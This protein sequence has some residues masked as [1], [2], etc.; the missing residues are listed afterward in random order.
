MTGATQASS[1]NARDMDNNM[2]TIRNRTLLT[3][4]TLV[5]MI[6]LNGCQTEEVE[7]AEAPA[8]LVATHPVKRDITITRDYVCQIHSNRHIELRTLEG[9]YLQEVAVKEGQQVARGQVMFRILPLVYQAELQRATAEAQAARLEYQNTAKL[10]ESN[11]VSATEL[12]LSKAK[13]EKAKAEVNLAQAHLNF[14]EIKAPFDGIMDRLHVR[15]GSLLEEGELLT[16]L[17]DNSLMWVYFNVPEA[18]YLDYAQHAG[19]DGEVR[20]DL[21]MANNE[22]FAHPGEMAT[23]EAEFNNATGTIPFR[24]DFANPEGLLRHGQTGNILMKTPV[25]DALLIP[26]KATFEILDHNYV[27]VIDE[28]GVVKQRRIRVAE[29]LEDLFA[30]EEG[31]T[32]SDTILL[33]GLRQVRDGEEVDYELLE[34]DEALSQL[35]LTAE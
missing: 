33:E 2:P 10:A 5:A 15:E 21:L 7:H 17:S 32:E 26:Q 13:L 4:V 22:L 6:S 31:L 35:K 27:F 11:V 1:R 23:I 25:P 20:L 24:A 29:E 3:L 34:P 28:H 8:R 9:G 18:E 12:A 14:T 16:T 19:K 30:V